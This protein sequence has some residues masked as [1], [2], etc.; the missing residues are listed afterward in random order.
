M[1]NE[2][3]NIDD[4]LSEVKKR[5]EENEKEIKERAAKQPAEQKPKAQAQPKAKPE[6]KAQEKPQPKA[7][8]KPQEKPEEKA[9]PMPQ[10]KPAPM[11]EKKAEKKPEAEQKKEEMID[12]LDIAEDEEKAAELEAVQQ[13]AE[14][15]K[16]EKAKKEKV[17]RSKTQKI[18]TSV[19]VVLLILVLTAGGIFAV[20]ANDWLKII[21][22]NSAGEDVTVEE[23]KG[24]NKLVESFDPIEEADAENVASLEDMVRQWYYNGA[25][26]SSTHVLNVLLIGE[27]TRGEEIRDDKTRA[28]AAIIA[29][30]NIDTK[31]IHLTSI[32]RDSWA[33]WETEPGNEES[34]KFGKLNGAMSTGSLDVYINS[35]ERL[36][37]I[38]IDGF[39]IV[40]FTSFEKIINTLYK[41]GIELEITEDE[42]NEI[43][44]HPGRYGKVKIKKTFEGDSGKVKLSGKQA[45]AY[46]RIRHIDTDNARADRQKTTLMT[47]FNDFRDSSSSK[48]IKFINQLVPYVKT[49]FK[50]NEII[51]IASY[52]FS[53]GWMDFDI[54]SFNYPEVNVTGGTFNNEFLSNWVWRADFPADAYDMQKRIYGKSSITL[55]QTRV[56]VKR[57]RRTG[58]VSDGARPTYYTIDNE[59]Y[60]EETT[61]A[62]DHTEEDEEEESEE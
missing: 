49:S 39:A 18:L 53:H 5:R 54:N 1:S 7:E 52:A 32:L 41:D 38:D 56:D 21:A 9:K 24:M 35:V 48:K 40:N 46:C 11:P 4:I 34:G 45:L 26:C 33:Y 17:P 12:L 10:E 47:I 30:V 58:F 31:E 13:E 19:I 28:D 20:K 62:P 8:P 15:Q 3:Y 6:P 51:K 37:K 25:P 57:V 16:A 22:N 2:N 50:K 60:Q 43:N 44:N 29:S 59:N 27:D 42:I 36:Y 23:W 61:I 14:Q 55:A